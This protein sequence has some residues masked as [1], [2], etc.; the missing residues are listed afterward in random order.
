MQ[1]CRFSLPCLSLCFGSDDDVDELMKLEDRSTRQAVIL[2]LTDISKRKEN[3]LEIFIRALKST[4]N[5]KLHDYL[6]Q[7]IEPKLTKAGDVTLYIVHT[8]DVTLY[9]VHVGD[10]RLKPWILTQIHAYRRFRTCDCI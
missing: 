9:N 10:A 1:S 4:N 2:L 5:N 6:I 7:N 8:C 3:W